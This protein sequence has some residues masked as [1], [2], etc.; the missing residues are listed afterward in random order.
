MAGR[1]RDVP[2]GHKSCRHTDLT[3]I[4]EPHP[5]VNATFVT[6]K[7]FRRPLIF[8]KL[9][10]NTSTYDTQY[11][12]YRGPNGKHGPHSARHTAHERPSAVMFMRDDYRESIS[13]TGKRS[14]NSC[15]HKCIS[16]LTSRP[17]SRNR[18]MI[19]IRRRRVAVLMA[20]LQA[21]LFLDLGLSEFCCLLRT[22]VRR[23][24]PSPKHLV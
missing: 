7:Y 2:R 6:D 21:L 3:R 19:S 8:I 22:Q 17:K 16:E 9:F 15:K 1:I 4:C 20:F 5:T 23:C 24:D 12:R 10:L 14:A 13:V 11:S 18:S